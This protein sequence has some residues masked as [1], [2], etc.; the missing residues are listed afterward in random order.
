MT[1]YKVRYFAVLGEHVLLF[2][3]TI[4]EIFKHIFLSIHSKKEFIMRWDRSHQIWSHGDSWIPRLHLVEAKKE[5]AWGELLG[6]HPLPLWLCPACFHSVSLW[7]KTR[8]LCPVIS[9][10]KHCLSL[11]IKSDLERAT[12][13]Y[14]FIPI[15]LGKVLTLNKL[16]NLWMGG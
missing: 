10:P 4:S 12:K 2:R 14:L 3:R 5:N 6:S 13:A 9:F 1:H 15:C 16:L 8:R 11:I 7:Y